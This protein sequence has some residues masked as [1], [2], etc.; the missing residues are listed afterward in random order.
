MKKIT[1]KEKRDICGMRNLLKNAGEN[2]IEVFKEETESQMLELTPDNWD[3]YYF[4][5]GADALSILEKLGTR[6]FVLG[7]SGGQDSALAGYV[8]QTAVRELRDETGKDYEFLALLLPYGTQRDGDE[9]VTIAKDFIKADQML[10]PA[11]GDNLADY[12]KGNV[13]ARVR[14]TTQYA[15][16]G[17]RQLLV[18]GTDHAAEAV[19]GFF[20]EV[21]GWSGLMRLNLASPY[22]VLDDYLEGKTV[23]EAAQQ[24]IE[25]RYLVTEHK[26]QQPVDPFADWW[27]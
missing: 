6:G 19:S 9:A 2:T 15:Y 16:A 22:D 25:L 12:H 5:Q 20:H 8:A 4:G 13:K 18:V 7:I 26:R 24:K 3:S 27:K 21:R 1:T 17:Q 11:N 10:T 23:A 14:A